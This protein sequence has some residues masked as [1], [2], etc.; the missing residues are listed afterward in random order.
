MPGF[1]GGRVFQFVFMDGAGISPQTSRS[2]RDARAVQGREME[3][4]G[5]RRHDYSDSL[6]AHTVHPC[7]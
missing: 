4:C 7:T 6:Y 5:T 3:R 2:R 1:F